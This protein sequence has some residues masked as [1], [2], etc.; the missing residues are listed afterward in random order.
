MPF[1]R[2]ERITGGDMLKV[3]L[4]LLVMGMGTVFSFL[5]ILIFTMVITYK[6]LTVI[7]KFFPEAVVETVPA[8]KTSAA[9][10]VEI[11][12]AIAATKAL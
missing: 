11:A 5:V 4:T 8:K 9:D 1:K 12:I 3:G 6:V 7:N 2:K 10:D